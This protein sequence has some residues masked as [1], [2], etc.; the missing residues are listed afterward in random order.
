MG[1]PSAL[2]FD[3]SFVGTPDGRGPYRVAQPYGRDLAREST[4]LSEHASAAE[5]F[6]EIDRLAEQMVRTG[7]PSNA[8]ELMVLDAEDRVIRR[9]DTH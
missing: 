2:R 3:V 8:I 6:A 1:S 7:A 5:A 4:T 9:P